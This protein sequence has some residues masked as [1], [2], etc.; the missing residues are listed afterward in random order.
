MEATKGV[1]KPVISVSLAINGNKAEIR[2]ADNGPKLSRERIRE[3]QVKATTTKKE[4]LGLGLAIV[5]TVVKDH[6]G[7]IVISEN[8]TAGLRILIEFPLLT[9]GHQ[10]WN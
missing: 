5:K 8:D 2:V 3:I 10:S 4:G 7:R 9:E 6:K 1:K